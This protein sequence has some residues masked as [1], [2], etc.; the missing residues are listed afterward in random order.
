[1]GN[2][3]R[4]DWFL[5]QDVRLWRKPK[6]EMRELYCGLYSLDWEAQR[7]LAVRFAR[8]YPRLFEIFLFHDRDADSGLLFCIAYMILG[9][10]RASAYASQHAGLFWTVLDVAHA[11]FTGQVADNKLV[12]P[13]LDIAHTSTRQESLIRPEAIPAFKGKKGIALFGQLRSLLQHEEIQR[14]LA[15]NPKMFTRAVQFLNVFVGIQTQIKELESHVEF[16]VDWPRTF[17]YLGDLSKCAREIAE[18]LKYIGNT[19][20]HPTTGIVSVNPAPIEK[21]NYVKSMIELAMRVYRD[22]CL[23]SNVLD[24]MLYSR[25]GYNNHTNVLIPGSTTRTLCIDT[26]YMQ[27]F[28]FHSY[29]DLLFAGALQQID[30][31]GWRGRT[32]V[33]A[34][35][36]TRYQTVCDAPIYGMTGEELLEVTFAEFMDEVVLDGTQPE[37]KDLSKLILMEVPLQSEL[38]VLS[39]KLHSVAT[40]TEL[41]RQNMPS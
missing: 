11:W 38:P 28:S 13:P 3:P 35:G 39:M 31:L 6:W 37:T 23:D 41:T 1:M 40:K 17:V 21:M 8:H 2:M 15:S 34:D 22:I 20:T 12:I 33:D 29:I 36:Q 25:M 24:K 10:G 19:I 5:L 32:D 27:A 18:S 16:E 9:N 4:L 30:V 14:M 7:S 26:A